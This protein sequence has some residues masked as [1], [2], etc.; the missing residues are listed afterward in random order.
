[1]QVPFVPFRVFTFLVIFASA[2][3]LLLFLTCRQAS[4]LFFLQ[5]A[6]CDGRVN[7]I[8]DIITQL[9]AQR[10]GGRVFRLDHQILYVL[11][12]AV[13][14]FGFQ[15]AHLCLGPA[16]CPCSGSEFSRCPF[17]NLQRRHAEAAA[18]ATA[19]RTLRRRQRWSRSH[20]AAIAA[21]YGPEQL[22]PECCAGKGLALQ[23][24]CGEPIGVPNFHGG[25]GP[26]YPALLL[27]PLLPLLF[28]LV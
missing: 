28:L 7:D 2:S 23:H 26:C 21:R 15:Q 14:L 4:R 17:G 16:F 12:Q 3:P 10:L 18:A 20:E 8:C 1:M 11:H 25:S 6:V 22:S 27:L 24:L 13:L 9:L 5:N 19:R